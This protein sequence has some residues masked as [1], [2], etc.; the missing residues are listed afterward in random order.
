MTHSVRSCYF[1]LD[2]QESV[3]R[4]SLADDDDDDDDRQCYPLA[5]SFGID[6]LN[7]RDLEDFVSDSP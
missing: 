6:C 3:Q 2:Q 7:R 1:R 5:L 4:Y